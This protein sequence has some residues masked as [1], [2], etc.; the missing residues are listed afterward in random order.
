MVEKSLKSNVLHHKCPEQDALSILEQMNGSGIYQMPVVSEDG[1]IG[2]II[3]DNRVRLFH[4]RSQL[5][6]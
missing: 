4:D 5:G 6:M 2:Q 3:R 1:I